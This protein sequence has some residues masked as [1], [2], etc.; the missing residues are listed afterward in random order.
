MAT[1]ADAKALLDLVFT[2]LTNRIRD[3]IKDNVPT[4]A[5]TLGQAINLLAKNS[6]TVDPADQDNLTSLRAQLIEAAALRRAKN[7]STLALVQGDM[8]NIMED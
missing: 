3:D 4:D 5:A 1:I 6:I 7:S 2:S 8:N